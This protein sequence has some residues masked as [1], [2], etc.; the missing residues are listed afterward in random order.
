LASLLGGRSDAAREVDI[1][2][3][4]TRTEVRL[5]AEMLVGGRLR[6]PQEAYVATALRAG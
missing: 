6:F 5:A 3:I 2:Q 4:A 1:R